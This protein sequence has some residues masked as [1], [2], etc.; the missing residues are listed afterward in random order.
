MDLTR[1]TISG[2][3]NIEHTTIELNKIMGV[4]SLNNYG[5]SNLLSAI[6]FGLSFMQQHPKI[7]QNMMNDVRCIPFLKHEQS[8]VFSF[9]MECK[10]S[11]GDKNYDIVYSYSFEW[12]TSDDVKNG[13]LSE[14][15]K[16]K[17]ESQAFSTYIKRERNNARYLSSPT[18]R[19]VSAISIESNDLIINKLAV[20]D[21]LFYS[22]IIKQLLNINVYVDRH[23]DS[24]PSYGI[25][26]MSEQE[27]IDLTLD[28]NSNIPKT[29]YGI[30]KNHPEKFQLLKN[31]FC[32]LFPSI[33]DIDSREL[34]INPQL[35]VK[36]NENIRS[37]YDRMYSLFVVD[38]HLNGGI[39]FLAMSDGARRVLLLLT[40]IILAQLNDYNLICIEEP[41][42]S[43]HPGLLRKFLYAISELAENTKI[44]FSSHS[45]YLIN[46]MKPE[47]VYIGVP[48]DVGVAEF[49]RLKTGVNAKKRLIK[50]IESSNMQLGD[51]LFDLMSGTEED[52]EEL[53]AYVE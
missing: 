48:N 23:F 42:N 26:F 32:S 24:L 52:I 13:V 25:T 44:L 47:N 22:T 29:L 17:D 3:R 41:E 21:N 2:Y 30:K 39:N 43:I 33:T 31:V 15:L 28:P 8:R 16:I 46:Y 51:Y 34:N 10:T 37:V 19:C 11:S 1:V 35:V 27:L 12:K 6:V 20:F 45:P 4:L 49:K 50:E 38:K 36:S 18:G 53:I 14:C 9:E 7:K 40:F 5:K